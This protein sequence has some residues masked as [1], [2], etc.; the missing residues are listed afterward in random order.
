[1]W[2]AAPG[3]PGSAPE[4]CHCSG[5]NGNRKSPCRAPSHCG[6]RGRW[7]WTTSCPWTGPRGRSAEG[8]L[9]EGARQ[10]AIGGASATEGRTGC[11]GGRLAG[12]RQATR[13]ASWLWVAFWHIPWEDGRFLQNGSELT[14]PAESSPRRC[15]WGSALES[16]LP[17]WS[18]DGGQDGKEKRGHSPQSHTL[19][20]KAG[21]WPGKQELQEQEG[22]N[23]H[24]SSAR[25][26]TLTTAPWGCLG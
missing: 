6:W 8:K 5:T 24:L 9:Q 7:P 20:N 1:M 3:S 16:F 23:A 22:A 21:S 12:G 18:V 25:P 13:H 10:G 14:L 19:L 11:V 17:P 15:P 2:P 4:G 26:H